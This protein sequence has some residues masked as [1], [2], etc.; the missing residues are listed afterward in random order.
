LRDFRANAITQQIL[1]DR[2]TTNEGT[3]DQQQGNTQ[4]LQDEVAA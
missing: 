1:A 2:L 3:G 4:R